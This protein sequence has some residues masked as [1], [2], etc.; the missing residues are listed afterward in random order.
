MN[1]EMN[2]TFPAISQNEGFAR[3]VVAA[4]AAQ[5]NPTLEA[6]S[7]IRTAVSEAVTN[8]II[9][10]YEQD[11]ACIIEMQCVLNDRKLSITVRDH[12][13]GISDIDLARKPFYT[14]KPELERSGMGFAVM[15]A[16]MDGM[17][18]T[19]APDRGTTVH[20][21]KQL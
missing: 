5:A 17:E 14:T 20:L 3:A 2:L 16:F 6:L 19:S 13:K 11:P 7:D 9:H 21:L 12:G 18:V 8:C 4:F 1:N 10:G 15:E